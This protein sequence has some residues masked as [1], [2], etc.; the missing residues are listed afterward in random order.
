MLPADRVRVGSCPECETELEHCH[1][2]TV[3]HADGTVECLLDP[4]CALPLGEHAV[5]VPCEELVPGCRCK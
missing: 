4:A 2:M 5:S 1:G 3:I